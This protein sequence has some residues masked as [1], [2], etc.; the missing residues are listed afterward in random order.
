MFKLVLV[1]RAI[2]WAGISTVYPDGGIHQS[3]YDTWALCQEA[4]NYTIQQSGDKLAVYYLCVP[5]NYGLKE[6]LK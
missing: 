3:T 1:I 5:T 2:G 4:G 6:G